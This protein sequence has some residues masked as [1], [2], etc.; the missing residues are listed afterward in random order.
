MSRSQWVSC[1]CLP[2][3]NVVASASIA[4]ASASAAATTSA[5]VAWG[6][7]ATARTRTP[8]CASRDAHNAAASAN[9][10]VTYSRRRLS[11]FCVIAARAAV[12]GPER[13]PPTAFASNAAPALRTALSCTCVMESSSAP[14]ASTPGKNTDAHASDPSAPALRHSPS[15]TLCHAVAIAGTAPPLIAATYVCAMPARE[16]PFNTS[17][18]TVFGRHRWNKVSNNLPSPSLNS[19][20][21]LSGLNESKFRSSFSSFTGRTRGKHSRSGNRLFM[22]SRMPFLDSTPG[23]TPPT[24]RNARSKYSTGEISSVSS[25]KSR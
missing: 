17:S 7:S 2:G 12:R 1:S 9:R 18:P 14:H 22:E 23:P 16:A 3:P 13:K 24:L 4:A 21:S 20:R 5:T 6:A 25:E 10:F 15:A 19:G 8:A 11:R